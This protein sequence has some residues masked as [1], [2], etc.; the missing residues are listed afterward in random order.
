M[1]INNKLPPVGNPGGGGSSSSP[2]G[3]SSSSGGGGSSSVPGSQ[4]MKLNMKLKLQGV[5]KKPVSSSP[6]SVKVK[7]GGKLMAQTSAY[8]TITYT[9]GDEGVWTGSAGLSAPPGD[10]YVLYVKGPKHLQKKI[11]DAAPSET[12]GGTYH[13]GE[14]KINLKAGDNDLNLSGILMLVGDLPENGTQ[15]GIIDSYDTSYV[16]QHLQSTK[17]DELAIADVNYDGGIAGQDYS[18]VLASLSIKYDEE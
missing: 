13:C 8:Q 11:C 9:V 17:A 2:G 7:L 15:N 5:S 3:G 6:I 14:G 10:G 18:L 12:S 4:A 1:A 16:R